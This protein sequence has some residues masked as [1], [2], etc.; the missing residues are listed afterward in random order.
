LVWQLG[1]GLE[2]HRCFKYWQKHKIS[3]FS[4]NVQTDSGAQSAIYSKELFLLGFKWL[5]H[6]ADH[7]P[8]SNAKV[9]NE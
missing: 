2:D 3:L 7:S 4:T 5:R 9:K 8:L 6:K 1:Y